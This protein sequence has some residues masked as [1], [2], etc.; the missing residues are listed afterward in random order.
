MKIYLIITIALITVCCNTGNKKDAASKE[1][2]EVKKEVQSNKTATSN[3]VELHSVTLLNKALK[4]QMPREFK[5]MDSE[6]LNLK[7]PVIP[8]KP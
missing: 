5:I 6:M 7:Y 2:P 4:V 1:K 8:F 3:K